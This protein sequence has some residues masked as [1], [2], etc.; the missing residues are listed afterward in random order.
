MGVLNQHAMNV[1]DEYVW[2]YKF[3][4]ILTKMCVFIVPEEFLH[5]GSSLEFGFPHASYVTSIF[6]SA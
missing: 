5:A 2:K 1:N 6:E 4:G 3:W